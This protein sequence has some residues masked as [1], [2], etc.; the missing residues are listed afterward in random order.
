[1][2]PDLQK[3]NEFPLSLF[4]SGKNCK[5]YLFFGAHTIS[6]KGTQYHCFRVW[7]PHARSVSLVGDFN[8][9]DRSQTPMHAIGGGVW[10]CCIPR[11]EQF[12][13]YKYSIEGKD[14][15]I[16]MKADPYGAHYE[17]RPATASKIYE[18]SY[19]W[20]DDAW[21]KAKRQRNIYKSPV[22]VYE[23]H[24]NSWRTNPDGSFLDYRT[25]AKQMIPYLQKMSYTH[26]EFMPLTEYPY[27]GSWGYQV[28]GYFAPTSRFGTPDDFRAMVDAFHAAG[29]GV[30][31]DWVPAHFPKDE[32][33]L[34]EFDGGCCY[35]YEDVRK[36]EHFA[37][38]TKVF[39]YGR[40][41]VC[42][43]LISSA[44]CWFE[45]FHVDGLRVDA[46]ASM[47]Y[48]DYDRPD[49]QWC[50][51]KNGGRE[52]LEAIDFLRHLNEAVFEKFPDA[53]MIA[54]ESTAW[55]M[56]TK[57]TCDGGLGFNFKWNMG[58]MNDMLSY[59]SMDPLFRSGNH[60]KLTF[61][62][63][64]CFSENYVL[65]IS[66]DEVVHGKC[67]MIGKMSGGYDQKFDS[68]RAFLGYMMAHP[69]KKL[70]F[71]GQEFAQ[72]KEWDYQ[73]QLDWMLLDYPKHN[74]ML[75]YTRKLNRF[76][77]E[78]PPLWER[79]DSW[80]G[81][82]WIANDDYQQSVIAFRRFDD[83]GEELIVVC[84]FVPVERR[85][86]R[87]GV[88]YKGSYKLLFNSDATEFGGS[89]AAEKAV[90]SE[91][92]PMHGFDNSIALT[93]APLSTMFFKPVPYKK[94]RSTKKSAPP[95]AAQK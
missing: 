36:G 79:D 32:H 59:M 4:L 77:A 60:D 40:P 62:F 15:K 21:R 25:F 51:N 17:T 72:M 91:A 88:P 1:M 43:F 48:L 83:K 18:S 45:E 61:S 42:S 38:G 5:S 29:I 49:G 8:R 44:C 31:L 64:Y 26:I 80:D 65:P 33:G 68:Y 56:V 69:G 70:L 10:E 14:G 28:T 27:D 76:Y 6:S 92:I 30:I 75:K 57:P 2:I 54:E 24:F 16:R 66:H 87:I 58:W 9:W 93:L 23:V 63:F 85:E 22:N 94:R 84:N 20:K 37:W 78:H 41:E 71:M 55:P 50:P 73:Q 7:A 74:T 47:L 67:S 13:A 34:F 46:V 82:S 95:K 35:E 12:A 89:G 39:D 81:F 19:E 52:N 53:L 11:L 90:K 3:E 86:Y